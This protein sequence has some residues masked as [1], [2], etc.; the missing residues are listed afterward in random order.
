MKFNLILSIILFIF[1]MILALSFLG[2]QLG[3]WL[4]VVI[5]LAFAMAF[6][7]IPIGGRRR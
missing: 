2:F 7:F 1:A 3:N 6:L 5:L 4:Y